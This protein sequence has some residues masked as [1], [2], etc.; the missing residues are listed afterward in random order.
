MALPT[1]W[2]P[3]GQLSRM[4]PLTDFDELI[5][6][7]G[8]RSLARE[9]E[10]TLEMRLDVTEDDNNYLVNV[11]MPGVKKDD[12]DVSIE[13][14][15]VTLR[16]EVNREKSRDKGK[17]LYNER[18]S[19]QVFRAFTLPSEIDSTK[20]QAVYDGG[21]LTLTLPKKA[22]TQAKRLSVN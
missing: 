10:K 17:E 7:I 3:F 18:Y 22:G 14:N 1:R 13:G 11:D 2:N 12:I 21:V 4:D 9:F 20:A 6:G 15:Q 5:R 19:G 16:A 8:S